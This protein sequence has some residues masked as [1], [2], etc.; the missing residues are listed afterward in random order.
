MPVPAA[1]R[2]VATTDNIRPPL[3]TLDQLKIDFAH[4]EK[5]VLQLE[6]EFAEIPPVIEDEDDLALATALA[7]KLIKL[8]KRCE[9]IRL[10]Q[11]RPFLDASNLLNA[12]FKHDLS[13]RLT[14]RKTALESISTAFQRKKAVREQALREQRAAAARKLAEEA[15]SKVSDAVRTGD[16]KA[17]TTAVTEANSLTAFANKA[18]VAAAEPTSSMG[19]V[20]TD[21]GAASLIDNWV[22]DGVDMNAIDL[23]M[24]RPFIKQAAIEQALRDFI[25]AGYREIT[26]ARI[27]NNS[28]TR[29][30]A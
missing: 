23:V 2:I 16:I 27:F 11:N 10:E 24:L 29:F 18:A 25:K 9:E 15:A 12:H 7:G 13:A 28:K 8:A 22:F 19:L 6:A 21:A 4:V 17:A 26:G 30:R 5:A 1:S 3:V 14:A 20:R